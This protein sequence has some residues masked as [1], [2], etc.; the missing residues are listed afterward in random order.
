MTLGNILFFAVVCLYLTGTG[1]YLAGALWRSDRLRRSGNVSAILGF[2]LHTACLGLA[3][4]EEAGGMLLRAEFYFSLLAWSLLLIFFF[5]WWRLRLDFLGILTSP[6]PCTF[7]ILPGRGRARPL[8]EILSGL[9]FGLH[10]GS[11]FLAISLL[12]MACATGAGYLYLERKIKTKEKLAGFA[13]AM[14]SLST[15]DR[16]NQWAVTGGFPLYTIGLVS[17][18]LWAKLTWHRIFSWDPKEVVPSSSGFCSPSCSTSGC[19]W[20]GAA[21]SRPGWPSGSSP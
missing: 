7:F 17:G 1:L 13:R 2:V 15:F 20:A 10:I 3:L 18:F 12:A 6:L 16:A 8:P 21:E 5:L 11:L 14:P 4:G 19:F 9:F